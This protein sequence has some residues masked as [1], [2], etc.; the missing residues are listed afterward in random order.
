[1]VDDA[2]LSCQDTFDSLRMLPGMDTEK[3][4]QLLDPADKQNVP[5]AVNLLQKL[6]TLDA[7]SLSDALPTRGRHGAALLFLARFFSLFLLPFISVEMTLSQQL[8]S[9]ITFSH[10]LFAMWKKHGTVKRTL[11]FVYYCDILIV[12][13]HVGQDL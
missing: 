6:N 7:D 9:L 4:A 5:K 13:I 8:L 3:A 11:N 2:L 10:V 1:M 12:Y